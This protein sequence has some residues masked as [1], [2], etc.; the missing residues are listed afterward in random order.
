M[1]AY[2]DFVPKVINSNQLLGTIQLESLD[3]ITASVNQWIKQS[4]VIVIN[5]ETLVLRGYWDFGKPKLE[6]VSS[7]GF[8]FGNFE[9]QCVRVWYESQ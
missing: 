2:R 8:V 6:G 5:V 1:I 9:F 3:V 4:Q 7:Q